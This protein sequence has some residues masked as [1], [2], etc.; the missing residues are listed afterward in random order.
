MWFE[1]LL[2]YV[3][4]RSHGQVIYRE[5]DA[6]NR[7]TGDVAKHVLVVY[8]DHRKTAG[9]KSGNTKNLV[10]GV[11]RD[12]ERKFQN[13]FQVENRANLVI[14]SNLDYPVHIEPEE[15]RYSAF[16]VS[17]KFVGNREYHETM[18]K[19]FRDP[20]QAAKSAEEI[21]AHL[22]YGV[23]CNFEVG[24][25]FSTPELE[26]IKRNSAG[27]TDNVLSWLRC[28]DTHYPRLFFPKAEKEHPGQWSFEVYQSYTALPRPRYERVLKQDEFVKRFR[29]L[30]KNGG[31]E[32][33]TSQVARTVAGKRVNHNGWKLTLEQVQDTVRKNSSNYGFTF[34]E[35][36]QAATEEC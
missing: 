30:L 9:R 16:R 4:G 26:E 32:S 5:D 29:E 3:F 10:T 34:E 20:G 1:F 21:Y 8:E 35:L 7:Y 6:E 14:I 25:V 24:K 12:E 17:S 28:A 22:R 33:T 23:K 19:L 31:L 15:R 27:T 36:Y 13:R 11:Y 2:T 18:A